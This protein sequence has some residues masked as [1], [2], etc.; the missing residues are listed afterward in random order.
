M[1]ISVMLISLTISDSRFVVNIH[2]LFKGRRLVKVSNLEYSY[3]DRLLDSLL[4]M[5]LVLPIAIPYN[6]YNEKN[7][8]SQG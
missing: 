2:S 7:T 3:I 6:L 1:V 4:S 8:Y 5:R